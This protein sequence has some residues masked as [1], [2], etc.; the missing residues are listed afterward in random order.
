MV[1][2]LDVIP[3]PP[4]RPIRDIV[5]DTVDT[6]SGVVQQVNDNVQSTGADGKIALWGIIAAALIGLGILI[7]FIAKYRK[8]V[9]IDHAI[10]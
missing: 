8:R 1:P 7:F 3:Y 4:P 5:K 2:F 10:V 6:V 9:Q